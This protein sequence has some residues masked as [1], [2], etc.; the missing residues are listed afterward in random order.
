MLPFHPE[1]EQNPQNIFCMQLFFFRYSQNKDTIEND[2]YINF[3][4]LFHIWNQIFFTNLEFE[5]SIALRN[6]E[7]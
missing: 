6:Q 4:S 7:N 5:T 2:I 1:S 3:P